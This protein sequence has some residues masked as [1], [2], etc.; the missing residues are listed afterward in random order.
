MKWIGIK[1]QLQTVGRSDVGCEIKISEDLTSVSR[2]HCQIL[3][4]RSKREYM[5]MDISDT[6]TWLSDGTKLEKYKH[7]SLKPRT[8]IRIGNET[9]ELLLKRGEK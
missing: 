9:C 1:E 2:Q 4:D 8:R 7:I 5:V 6:G 3:Y